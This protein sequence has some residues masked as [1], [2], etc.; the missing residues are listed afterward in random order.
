MAYEVEERPLI[1]NKPVNNRHER[2][3]RHADE[4]AAYLSTL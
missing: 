4:E 3:H 2:H 1:Y